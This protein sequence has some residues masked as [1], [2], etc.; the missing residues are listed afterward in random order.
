[1]LRGLVEGSAC[2]GIVTRLRQAGRNRGKAFAEAIDD[3]FA[4]SDDRTIGG[5]VIQLFYDLIGA[6]IVRSFESGK[7]HVGK[8]RRWRGCIAD[9]V[10][11]NQG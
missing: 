2:G 4:L 9:R 7:P 5:C 11:H 6:L 1:M 10:G 8:V 3:I